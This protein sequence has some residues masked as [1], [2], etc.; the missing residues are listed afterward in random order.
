MKPPKTANER[1]RDEHYPHLMPC[2]RCYYWRGHNAGGRAANSCPMCHFIIDNNRPRGC[3]PDYIR[4][5]C[6]EFVPRKPKKKKVI[7]YAAMR[8]KEKK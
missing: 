8:P 5:T 6:A 4:Q 1:Y 7:Y 3:E 2:V